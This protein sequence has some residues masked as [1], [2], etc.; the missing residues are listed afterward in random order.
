MAQRYGCSGLLIYSD[1]QDYVPNG[2][3]V[4]PDG[5]SLPPG[6]V[7]RG[8]LM[9]TEGDPLTPGVP[10]IG[11]RPVTICEDISHE[12]LKFT[13][14]STRAS[15]LYNIYIKHEDSHTIIMCVISRYRIMPR[16][17]NKKII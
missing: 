16:G 3:P 7:Q 1:P 2:V 8:S 11:K 9:I 17:Y 14:T 13:G 12:T 10:A 15:C 5:P 4:Y 6:G